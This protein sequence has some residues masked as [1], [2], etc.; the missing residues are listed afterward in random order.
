MEFKIIVSSCGHGGPFGATDVKRLKSI[1]L[2][3]E[4]IVRNV[5]VR[6]SFGGVEDFCWEFAF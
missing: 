6:G 1:D 2:I 4:T 3:V 5:I